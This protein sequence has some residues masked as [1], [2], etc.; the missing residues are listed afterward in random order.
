MCAC[1]RRCVVARLLCCLCVFG[2]LVLLGCTGAIVCC[3]G[4]C[5]TGVCVLLFVVCVV[6]ALCGV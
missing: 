3:E 2:L 5:V 1:V 6:R 4:G